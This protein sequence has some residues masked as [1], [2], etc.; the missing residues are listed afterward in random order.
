MT[1][2]VRRG[3]R[4]GRSSLACRALSVSKVPKTVRSSCA[5]R[6]A[7]VGR[8]QSGMCAQSRATPGLA[9]TRA[10][11]VKAPGLRSTRAH[12]APRLQL[13]L[14]HRLG[15]VEDAVAGGAAPRRRLHERPQGTSLSPVR[16]AALAAAPQLRWACT[17]ALA[18]W[19]VQVG[20]ARPRP[21]LRA[22]RRLQPGVRGGQRGGAPVARS[23][24]ARPSVRA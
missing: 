18:A 7:K 1:C 17:L 13:R 24:P 11:A 19:A 2:M 20:Q 3:A 23:P 4:R 15:P 21:L 6:G 12:P 5:W 9:A 8:A 22:A 10:A 14:A 16:S